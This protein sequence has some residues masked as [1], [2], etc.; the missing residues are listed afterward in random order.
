MQ[1]ENMGHLGGV[2]LIRQ[3]LLRYCRQMTGSDFEAE[4]LVQETIL[5]LLK[6][7]A[8]RPEQEVSF[9]YA[10]RAARNLWIDRTRRMARLAMVPFLEETVPSAERPSHAELNV[11]EH[12]EELAWRLPPKP[13]VILLLMDV[14]DFTARETA[15]LLGGT[16]VAVQ[17]ALSRARSRLQGMKK[18]HERW[19]NAQ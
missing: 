5:R 15:A 11:R 9:R 19:G 6:I 1:T 8:E 4:D 18:P 16:E 17:V 10:C 13:F 12:L 7:N 3:P 2:E 14:F